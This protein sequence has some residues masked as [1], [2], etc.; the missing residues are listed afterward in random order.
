MSQLQSLLGLGVLC[1]LAWACGGFRRG[2]S[3]RVVVGGV[4]ATLGSAALMHK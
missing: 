1:A 3:A 4:L 2:V